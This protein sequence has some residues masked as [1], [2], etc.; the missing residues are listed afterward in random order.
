MGKY[1]PEKLRIRTLF[2]QCY[3][4]CFIEPYVSTTHICCCSGTFSATSNIYHR[5]FCGIMK[6]NFE[7]VLNLVR[8]ELRNYVILHILPW[9]TVFFPEKFFRNVHFRKLVKVSWN[10][11]KNLTVCDHDRGGGKSQT[12][13]NFIGK[14]VGKFPDKIRWMAHWTH[15]HTRTQVPA[16]L[17]HTSWPVFWHYT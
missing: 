17:T 12:A 14:I 2:M 5:T 13:V 15:I 1:G 11:I 16:P 8:M 3:L 4:F 9:K 10:Y 7:N 6:G